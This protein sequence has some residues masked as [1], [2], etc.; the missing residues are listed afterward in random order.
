[1]PKS[2]PQLPSLPLYRVD[3]VEPGGRARRQRVR[4]EIGKN[5]RFDT[6]L[7]EAYCLSSW[8]ATV[9]DALVVAAAVQFCDHS[10]SRPS[11]SWGREFELRI[12][13]HS[14]YHWSS[15]P[16][17]TALH[18]ALEFLTGDRWKISFIGR[19]S[20]APSHIQQR[21]DITAHPHVIVPFSDG[22][23]SLAVALLLESEHGRNVIRVRL[24]SKSLNRDGFEH[25]RLPFTSL[26][27]RVRYEKRRSVETSGR[28]R[29]FKVALLGGI[30]AHLSK[31]E[32]I[33]LPES[34]QGALGPAL[35]PVGQAY[36][37]YRSHPAFTNR[38]VKLVSALFDRDVY[39]THPRL[40]HTKAETLKE[41]KVRLSDAEDW[42]DARSCWKDAR[43]VSVSG[44]LRQC[45]VCSACLL[46]R[47]SMHAIGH[48]EKKETFV[49]EDLT[50]NRFEDGAAPG[51]T[52]RKP[53]GTLYE[54][55]IAGTLQL[56]DLAKVYYSNAGQCGL[57][58][59]V[60]LLSSSLGLPE[61]TIRTNMV[62]LLQQ[63]AREWNGFVESL[64][65]ESF[66]SQWALGA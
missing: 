2:R 24:G 26:P 43:H 19:K 14:P 23:D 38:M 1:M 42:A 10:K 3:V 64:G 59:Q 57:S 40:W 11:A 36:E 8:D 44:R 27:F 48:T 18:G 7:I 37:D 47:M 16:I 32:Q 9:Y 39:F 31:A 15:Q 33:A 62:R 20:P 54:F 63:H 53:R 61:E 29:G 41:L 21:F 65:R 13:V 55:A 51:F 50:V 5:L 22:L 34:G 49:W 58:R 30:A 56:N 6:G 66:I 28:S 35:V 4:C 60:G 45:G 46:R 52:N 17:S 12:P 25:R